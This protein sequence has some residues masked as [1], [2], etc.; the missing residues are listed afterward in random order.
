MVGK[1]FSCGLS[2]IRGRMI[3]IEVDVSNG[4]PAYETVGLPDK[5]V[6][7]SKERIRA[8]IRNSHF[9]LPPRRITVNLAPANLRKEG[10]VYDLPIALGLLQATGLLGNVHLQ[11]CVVVGELS[12]DGEIRPI[13]GVLSMAMTA[14]KEGFRRFICPQSNAVEAAYIDG[15]DIIPAASL[16]DLCEGLMGYR[17][18]E[19][20][21]KIPWKPNNQAKSN[22]FSLIRGQ[23]LAKRAVEIAATGGHN[24]LMVGAPGTGKSMLAKAIPTILPDL[25][26]EEALEITC[27]HS[28]AGH[29]QQ[30]QLADTRP[31]L[32]PH[33][34]ASVPSL[35]GG[36]AMAKPGDISMAHQG[37]LFLDEMPEF[38]R[39]VLEALRQPLEDGEITVSRVHASE[40]YPAN[41]MLIGAM[42]PCPCGYYGSTQK[43]C[44]CLPKRIAQYRARLSGPLLDR[45]DLFVAMDEIGFQDFYGQGESANESSQSIRE[46]VNAGR[47]I[48]RMRLQACNIHCNAQMQQNEIERFCQLDAEAKDMYQYAFE[49]N[50]LSGRAHARTLRLARTIADLAQSE[51]IAEAHLAEALQ[52]RS[53]DRLWS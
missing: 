12:L 16:L 29:L 31:F 42:N 22:D 28:V 43:S 47:K 35:V 20:Q 14:K 44:H 39:N 27:I 37:V 36:G 17:L 30:G 18:L 26:F 46:R 11:D 21:Q 6:S 13:H 5:A 23:F 40:T 38:Q 10:S 7:E 19:T 2:G 25:S 3:T 41:F 45:I 48:Q 24:V 9:Q 1:V 52:Y 49:Q 15:L 51:R 4:L 53:F 32:S 50:H 8:A 33:H 34:S